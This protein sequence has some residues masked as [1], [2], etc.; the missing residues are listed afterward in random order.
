MG[1]CFWPPR[2]GCI[3]TYRR[4]RVTLL[5]RLIGSAIFSACRRVHDIMLCIQTN[6][7]FKEFAIDVKSK[8]YRLEIKSFKE[9]IEAGATMCQLM[10]SHSGA[11]NQNRDLVRKLINEM[12]KSTT[13][14]QARDEWNNVGSPT[15]SPWKVHKAWKKGELHQP[16]MD[17]RVALNSHSVIYVGPSMEWFISAQKNME[18]NKCLSCKVNKAWKK[19][20]MHEEQLSPN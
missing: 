14:A 11:C 3:K 8:D 2:Q 4:C 18:A 20:E 5:H 19:G 6:S 9:Q 10:E 1:K 13:T 12:A 17:E 15:G 16:N 7:S